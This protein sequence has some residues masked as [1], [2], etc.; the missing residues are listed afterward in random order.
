MKHANKDEENILWQQRVLG[1]DTPERL[2]C[3]V[4]YYIGKYVLKG[5][6]RTLVPQNF[7]VCLIA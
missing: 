4:F 6:E 2:L 5:R 1:D 7:T 3:A